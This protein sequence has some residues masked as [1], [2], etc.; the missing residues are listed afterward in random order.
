MRI[1]REPFTILGSLYG[2]AG[3]AGSRLCADNDLNVMTESDKEGHE[4]LD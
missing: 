2:D 3:G 4:A 1:C